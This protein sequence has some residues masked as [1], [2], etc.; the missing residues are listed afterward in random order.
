MMNK[1]KLAPQG[2]VKLVTDPVT[3]GQLDPK[4]L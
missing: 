1:V 2:Q 4:K 3:L